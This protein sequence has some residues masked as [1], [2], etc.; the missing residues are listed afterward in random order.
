MDGLRARSR[1][2]IEAIK[3]GA[4]KGQEALDRETSAAAESEA[5][6]VE[7]AKK[8]VFLL[9]RNKEDANDLSQQL[10]HF[11]YDVRLFNSLDKLDAALE[12][13]PPAVLL[14]D[15][16]VTDQDMSEIDSIGKITRK[17]NDSQPSIV[18]TG[19]NDFNIRL[20]TVRAG[21]DAVFTKP[22]DLSE[23]VETL[24]KV[25]HSAD[26]EPFRVLIVDDDG[27]MAEYYALL[28]E[29]SG[30]VRPRVETDPMQVMEAISDFDPEVIIMD[31]NMPGCNGIEL[32]SVIRQSKAY[33][34]IPIVFL[35]ADARKERELK[36]MSIGGDDFLG[37]PVDPDFLISRVMV[38]GDRSRVLTSLIT[39]DSMTGLTNHSKVKESLEAE[40]DRANRSSQPLSFAMID[41]DQFKQVNDTYG[42]W[43]GDN[44]I[45]AVAQVL[46]QRLRKTDIIGRYGGEEF[47][48]I[49]P[50]TSGAQA[51]KIMNSIREDFS[52]IRHVANSQEFFV[53][54]SVGIATFPPTGDPTEIA[55]SAD[56]ALYEA[57]SEGRNRVVLFD[58]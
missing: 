38:R 39:R 37:K 54:V 7:I 26:Q 28:L 5:E 30:S 56:E 25:T 13:T 24:D 2:L 40:L 46:R 34:H 3:T 20:E 47:A 58:A 35:T 15:V 8:L 52:Q 29:E 6:S 41:I 51:V 36:A 1:E 50:N 17:L 49:L 48:A 18:I 33:I 57:K 21:V 10:G 32:A 43:V 27:D 16:Q 31:I 45:K 55:T 9:E 11:G 4:A 53:T 12:E 14:M 19:R 42:H 44:V 23:M 22:L